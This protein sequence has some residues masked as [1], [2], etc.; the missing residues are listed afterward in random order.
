MQLESRAGSDASRCRCT[1]TLSAIVLLLRSWAGRSGG[2]VVD[3]RGVGVVGPSR[4]GAGVEAEQVGEHGYGEF[5]GELEQGGVAVG[6][7]VDA[8]RG[9][10]VAEAGRVRGRSGW[11]PGNSH[12]ES[13]ARC[14]AMPAG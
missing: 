8:E 5:G 13:S 1:R 7:G 11:R 4:C 14:A 3:V 6:A 10:A 2:G 9:E 12:G